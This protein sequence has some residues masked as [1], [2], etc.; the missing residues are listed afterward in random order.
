MKWLVLNSQNVNNT[1]AE[2]W[3]EGSNSEIN[4][5]TV[6]NW[7]WIWDYLLLSWNLLNS[8]GI[9]P[10]SC[11]SWLVLTVQSPVLCCTICTSWKTFYNSSAE[12]KV[13]HEG[14]RIIVVKFLLLYCM[15]QW[16]TVLVLMCAWTSLNFLLCCLFKSFKSFQSAYSDCWN[17]K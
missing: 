12:V 10:K 15:Y 13:G 5:S 7:N 2:R 17:S 9:S 3:H 16:M 11:W 8:P 14:K 1:Y 4:Q 6:Q